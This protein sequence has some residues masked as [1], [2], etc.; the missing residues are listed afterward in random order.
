MAFE[1]RVEF[2]G[3][4]LFAL[5]T[6]TSVDP[7]VTKEVT[8]L[9]PDAR[10]GGNNNGKHP[11][12]EDAEPHVGFVR[13][14]LADVE[15]RPAVGGR[16]PQPKYEVVHRFTGQILGFR[17]E[18]KPEPIMDLDKLDV[19]DFDKI[20]PRDKEFAV[21]PLDGIFE[22]TP[23]LKLLM[24]MSLRG[25]SFESKPTPI[26]WR[27]ST[28]LNYGGEP[29]EGRFATTVTWKRLIEDTHLVMTITDF[30]KQDP[31]AEFCLGPFKN[32]EAVTIMVGNAC[33]NPLAWETLKKPPVPK[34]DSDFKWLY[35]LLRTRRKPDLRF[36]KG[37]EL[38][39][40][41]RVASFRTSEE[42][43]MGG[44]ITVP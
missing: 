16:N 27:F 10:K 3:P 14:D 35:Q 38:P 24:R 9:M 1:L 21:E 42:A 41:V 44:K 26:A 7:P 12:G 29:H 25:G 2:S 23:P 40:P 20:A 5:H 4:C 31:E 22:N 28:A 13:L 36:P 33:H 30:N 15:P 6:D 11:D 8:V 32:G 19:P 18:P 39:A 37:L 17:E 34:I 43:C